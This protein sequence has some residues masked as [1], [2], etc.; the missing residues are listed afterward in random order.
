MHHLGGGTVTE[1]SRL[2]APT[3]APPWSQVIATTVRLWWRRRFARFTAGDRRTLPRI[4][5]L[6]LVLALA[7][8]TGTAIHLAESGQSVRLDGR[9]Q[10]TG[11]GSDPAAVKAAAV[12][13]QQAAAWVAAQVGH[14]VIVACDPAMCAALQQAGFPAA[15]V[16]AIG[17]ST[18]DP[19]G[20]GVVVSTMAV[21]DE[22]GSR[23]TSVYAPV[24]LAAFGAGQDL[25]Q[26]LAVAPD[27]AAAYRAAEQ[28]DAG[29][30]M[31]AGRQL[32]GNRN[33]H[34]SAAASTELT[35]GQVD[36]RLLIT[37]AALAHSYPV[38]VLW[39]SDSGP[40][41]STEVPLRAMAIRSTSSR[42]LQS[43]LTFLHAQQAPYL[44]L[45]YVSTSGS[46]SIVHVQFT[47]PSPP[48]LLTKI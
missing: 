43:V 45:T 33:L 44:A 11:R 42:Y 47:A 15:D 30:R 25:V 28:S 3:P 1:R 26:V 6:V 16:S 4:A 48:G 40:G 5:V 32:L 39:F 20:S 18:A 38:N 10:S 41:A 35:A 9:T 24:V 7:A 37:L 36:S 27:G 19:L 29:L 34:A 22:L 17:P 21:R 13:R 12:S 14:S 2:P 8:A 31:A 46:T 23:L